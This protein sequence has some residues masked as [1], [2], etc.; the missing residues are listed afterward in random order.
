[1]SSSRN[2]IKAH[3][4]ARLPA[5]YDVARST[6]PANVPSSPAAVF[7]PDS[8]HQA[9]LT[10]SVAQAQQIL[11]AAREQAAE[12]VRHAREQAA[13]TTRQARIE[14]RSAAEAEA[15]ELLLSAHGVYD[16]VRAWRKAMLAQSEHE[17]LNL[18]AAVARAIFGEGLAL[19]PER[20]RAAFARALAEARPLGDLRVH[21]HPDDAA[22]L[23]PHWPE[24]QG[25]QA[26]QRVELVPDA[27][28][29]RGG[30]LVEG[31]YGL[32]DA[33]VETQVD[34]ALEA[35]AGEAAYPPVIPPSPPGAVL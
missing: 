7:D 26:G 9:L 19:D 17:V 16:E 4:V 1:M 23:S 35:L 3:R 18:V 12:I 11:S 25:A 20:L 33:R 6:Y 2:V 31:D 34:L 14:G 13:E 8:A 32:V 15:G 5:E 21:V 24:L 27:G 22:L 28:V 10:N 29:R 30:C